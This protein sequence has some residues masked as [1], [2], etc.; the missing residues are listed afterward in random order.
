MIAELLEQEAPDPERPR[1]IWP[2]QPS[3]QLRTDHRERTNP[4]LGSSS[5]FQRPPP[6][7]IL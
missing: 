2:D 5:H 6:T 1:I 4:W 3:V 7:S